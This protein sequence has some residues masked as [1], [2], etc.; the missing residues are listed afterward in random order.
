MI[1]RPGNLRDFITIEAPN[2]VPDESG[3]VSGW[4]L[5]KKVY[6]SIESLSGR[7]IIAF[8][9]LQSPIN[10]R[11]RTYYFAGVTPAMRVVLGVRQMNIAYVADVDEKHEELEIL[12]VEVQ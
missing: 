10:V 9:E 5:F 1:L 8:R 12:C 11:I 4:V 2:T 3:Q 7:E 6:A